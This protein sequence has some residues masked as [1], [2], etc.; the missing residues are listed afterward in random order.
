M[1][2]VNKAIIVGNLGR[3]PET[4]YLSGG[5]AVATFSVAT[6]ESW[7]DKQTGEQKEN[8]EWHNVKAFGKLA[9]ICGEYLKKGSQVYIEGRIKTETWEKGGKTNYKT[10]IYADQMQM[11]GGAPTRHAADRPKDKPPADDDDDGIPPF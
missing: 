3:D 2:G 1:R 7:K 8:V 6:S 4:K 10:M 5:S 9:E 11:L